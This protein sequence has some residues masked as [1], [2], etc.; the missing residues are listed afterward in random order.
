MLVNLVSLAKIMVSND[1]DGG[2]SF[3]EESND[4]GNPGCGGSC[5][6]QHSG[7][8]C[9]H[10]YK[11]GQDDPKYSQDSH[12][13]AE[14]EPEDHKLAAI[15]N[16]HTF[17][18]YSSASF[19]TY[20]ADPV[21]LLHGLPSSWLLLDSCSITDIFAN[22]DLLSDIQ[23]AP[24]PIWLCSNASC[25]QLTKQGMFGNYPYH[26]WHNP[27]GVANILSLSTMMRH[28]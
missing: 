23:D 8:G 27:K 10:V 3:Y 12:V 26:I 4:H 13:N 5:N 21:V 20:H 16:S 19:S 14:D 28:Y 11:N 22:S 24:Q 9:G 1:Q 6:I 2:M 17:F 15:N 7:C 25:I 18:H